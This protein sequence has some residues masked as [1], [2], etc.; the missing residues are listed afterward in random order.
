MKLNMYSVFDKAAAGY[1]RPFFMQSDAQAIRAFGDDAVRA[2][3]PVAAHPEDY[4]LARIGV[5]D[6]NTGKVAPEGVEIIANAWELV[7][8]AQTIEEGSLRSVDYDEE[9]ERINSAGGT[10]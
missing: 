9:V 8:K 3:S 5:F 10:A 4:S 6:D 7:A 2:D 1:T